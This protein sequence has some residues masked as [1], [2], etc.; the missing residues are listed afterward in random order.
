MFL[1]KTSSQPSRS[2]LAITNALPASTSNRSFH[3]CTNLLRIFLS[4]RMPEQ[5]IALLPKPPPALLSMRSWL[6]G[7]KKPAAPEPFDGFK[8]IDGEIHAAS[9]RVFR[10]QP[11]RLMRVFL[12]AQQRGLRLHPDLA[13]LIRNQLSL[14]DRAF[15]SDEHVRETFLSILTRSAKFAPI[16]PPL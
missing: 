10:D 7:G 8:F 3:T 4:T 11:R 12:Y 13:Q 14:L 16:F 1:S 2:T 15:L 9:N 5:P 6:P